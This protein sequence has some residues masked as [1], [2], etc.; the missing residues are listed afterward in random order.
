LAKIEIPLPPLAQ[1][2]RIAGILDAADALRAKRRQALAQLDTL[3]QATFLDLFGDPVINPKGW[4]KLRISDVAEV[5]TGSTPSRKQPKFY[6]D[7]IEWIK[8]DNINDPSFY[9]TKAEEGLSNEGMKVA[10]SAPPGS[11]LVTCI[12]GSPSCIGNAAIADRRVAFNQQINAMIPNGKVNVF[13]AFTLFWVAPN[14]I[15]K[16]S[17]NSMK[18]MVSKSAFSDI[19]VPVPPIAIQER[20]AAIFEAVERQ[21]R[22]YTSHLADLD[23][24]FA[25]LQSRAFRGELC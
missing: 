1:Q 25:S 13:F 6:G 15:Q 4:E 22:R 17:T 18:G 11:V 23:T 7:V 12:A 20:F 3:L 5:V 9:L 24:L 21:K 19:L 2:K 16:A 8:S 14:L 10:R